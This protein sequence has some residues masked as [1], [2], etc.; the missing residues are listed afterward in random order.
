MISILLHFLSFHALLSMIDCT[1]VCDT[2]GSHAHTGTNYIFRYIK[3]RC[4]VRVYGGTSLSRSRTLKRLQK[5]SDDFGI[6]ITV[7]QTTMSR[8][9]IATIREVRPYSAI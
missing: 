4:T 7:C 5:L 9:A 3:V 6:A 8:V 2:Y 1:C